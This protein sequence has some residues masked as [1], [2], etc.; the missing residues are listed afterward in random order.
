M[1]SSPPT[2]RDVVIANDGFVSESCARDW[3]QRGVAVVANG[4]LS[5]RDGRSFLLADALRVLGPQSSDTDPYGLTGRVSTLR[6][7][8]QQGAV[9]HQESLRLGAATYDVEFGY[10]ARQTGS[11]DESG[12]YAKA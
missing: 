8:I 11:A 2:Q 7:L 10:V 5:C 6:E 4:V 12:A 3:A 9:L 1:D